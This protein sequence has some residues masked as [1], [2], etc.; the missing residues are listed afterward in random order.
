MRGAPVFRVVMS[1]RIVMIETGSG[2]GESYLDRYRGY[3]RGYV[4]RPLAPDAG[5]RRDGDGKKPAQAS[6]PHV[7]EFPER[8]H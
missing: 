7:I 2:M 8:A 5:A 1:A 3:V 4:E 6:E